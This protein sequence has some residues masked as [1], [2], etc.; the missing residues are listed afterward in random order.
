MESGLEEHTGVSP[1]SVRSRESLLSTKT[2]EAVIVMC[3]TQLRPRQIIDWFMT[4]SDLRLFLINDD[5][6]WSFF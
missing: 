6:F 1:L 3:P 2:Y 4:E 5:R